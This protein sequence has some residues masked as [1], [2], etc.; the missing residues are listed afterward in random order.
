[1]GMYNTRISKNKCLTTRFIP[2][3]VER[4]IEVETDVTEGIPRDSQFSK[5]MVD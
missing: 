1:V 5:V 3:R 2:Q 4:E